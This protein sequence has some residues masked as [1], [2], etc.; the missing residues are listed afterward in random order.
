MHGDFVKLVGKDIQKGTDTQLNSNKY[1]AHFVSAVAL[2]SNRAF[3]VYTPEASFKMYGTIC[4][5]EGTTITKGE[6]IQLINNTYQTSNKIVVKINENKVFIAYENVGDGNK[7]YGLICTIN[8]NGI[9]TGT[10]TLLST[11]QYSGIGFSIVALSESRVFIGYS[12]K[13]NSALYGLICTVSE[14]T[15][16]VGTQTLLEYGI[17]NAGLRISI[18]ALSESKVFIGH[19]YYTEKFLYGLVCTINGTTITKGTDKELNSKENVG[20]NIKV[21]ALSETKIC[22]VYG[23]NNYLYGMICTING[24]G[25]TKR[26]DI[27]LSL[28]PNLYY[29]RSVIFLNN[30]VFIVYSVNMENNSSHYYLCGMICIISE[31]KI[32]MEINAFLSKEQNSRGYYIG[33]KIKRRYNT[34]ST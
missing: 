10:D 17:T 25:I 23:L 27:Q 2:D 5:I 9:T 30:K 21:V 3:I 11:V 4:T 29:I 28:I 31:N 20:D 7:L 13:A 18:V 22:I 14:N 15:I 16:T 33:N 24:T 34:Y 19:S 1:S 32:T 12:N 26:T 8:G 6:D